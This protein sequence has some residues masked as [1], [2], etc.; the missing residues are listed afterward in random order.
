[1]NELTDPTINSQW[2][3]FEEKVIS[4]KKTVEE[5]LNQPLEK[6]KLAPIIKG[7]GEYEVV[8]KEDYDIKVNGD[9]SS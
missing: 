9:S 2:K 3:S 6:K 4:E 7:D 8:T 5:I 1:M